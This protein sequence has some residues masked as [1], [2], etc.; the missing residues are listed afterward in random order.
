M[1]KRLT[2]PTQSLNVRQQTFEEVN[3]GLNKSQVILEA[4]RCLQC[5][6]QP[7]VGG[8]PVGV[9]IP[10]FIAQVKNDD[11][12]GALATILADN[13][14]PSV[15]GRVCPQEKQCEAQC[16][17]AKSGQSIAIGYLE[18]Y[19]GDHGQA[20]QKPSKKTAG[21]VAV[22]GG[23]PAGISC[24]LVCAQNDM[25]VT[26]FDTW[27]KLGGVLYYGIPSFRLPYG[28]V[29][30]EVQRLLELGVTFEKN[31]IIGVSMPLEDLFDQGYQAVFLATG[32]GLPSLPP[33]ENSDAIG[34]F[35]ANEYLTRIN[36][37]DAHQSNHDTPFFQGKKVVVLGGGNVAMDAAR[38]ALRQ[39]AE[40]TIAYRR[41]QQD[42]PARKEE[43]DHAL[44][45]GIKLV[46][47]IQPTKII[48]DNQGYVSHVE[49]VKNNVVG[50]D[51]W[52]RSILEV[53]QTAD[54]IV[55]EADMV[56]LALGTKPNKLLEHLKDEIHLNKR[57]CIIVDE[58]LQTT[59]EHV[60]A[61]GDA[62][63]GAATVILALGQG[64][65][66]AQHIVKRYA[67]NNV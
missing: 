37:F 55:L 51:E 57:G 45:E 9:A 35:S 26:I 17:Y 16:V 62:V 53:D 22:V 38:C 10:Q 46:E 1:S 52:N 21:K 11:F 23:G 47:L 5:K 39:R 2:M 20:V 49:F 33:L 61:G 13:A 32:A 65:T 18:R 31:M 64:K 43:V 24:A 36:V 30:K 12:D 60:Y 67:K 4:S 34:V 8:C 41:L 63:L 7:C 50:S 66:A 40:V 14:L 48:K 15:C 56:I 42:M 19:V 59:K 27:D 28:V 3:V 54:P 6:H 25:D 29:D 58:T 44:E